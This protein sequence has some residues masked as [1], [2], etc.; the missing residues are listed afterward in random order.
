MAVFFNF[1][2]GIVVTLKSLSSLLQSFGINVFLLHRA[3]VWQR[4]Q[5][6]S[7]HSLSRLINLL[8][9]SVK[10][11]VH[12]NLCMQTY[13]NND[14]NANS[15]LIT[16]KQAIIILIICGGVKASAKT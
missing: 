10:N 3:C 4:K 13:N 2:N 5:M 7:K 11:S 1:H 6:I 15:Y 8:V 16:C 14:F 12:T 9:F